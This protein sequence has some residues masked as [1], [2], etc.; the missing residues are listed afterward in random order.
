MLEALFG[1]PTWVSIVALLIGLG[2][3]RLAITSS[4]TPQGA[5]AWV[6]FLLSLPLV[7]IPAWLIFGG[8]SS[9]RG[10]A[11]SPSG[12]YHRTDGG[13]GIDAFTAVADEDVTEG[14]RATLLIDGGPTYAAIHEA[15]DEAREEVLVQFYI[16]RDDEAGRAM[17]DRLVAA[18][19]RGV[20]VCVLCD[21]IGSLQLGRGFVET[22]REAGCEVRGFRG[23]GLA[24]TISVNFRNHRKCV[25]IDGR[26]LFTG[27]INCAQE[28]VDGKHWFDTW[29]DTFVRLDGPVAAQGRASF[30]RDWNDLGEKSLPNMP[31]PEATTGNVRAMLASPGPGGELERGSL[32]LCGLAAQARRR[33]W[34]TTPYLVPH[35][36]LLTALQVAAIRGVDVRILVPRPSDNIVAWYAARAYVDDVMEAGGE[37]REYLPGFMHQK[38]ALVDDDLVSIGTMNLDVRSALLNY[39]MTALI[40]D[41]D[42][43]A[44]VAEMLEADW[45][46]STDR[47][48]RDPSRRIR[49]FAPIARLMAPVL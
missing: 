2:V 13:D 33:L 23:R 30:A 10:S 44:E 22:M 27:G 35:D 38:V 21:L 1:V 36:D 41:R 28:Y 17:R 4:R 37:V 24:F 48:L 32:L 9:I 39:E 11:G 6:V 46:Q 42:F 34:M 31:A 26:T 20:R 15:I 47:H 19:R 43:A 14:N 29:R 3:A 8:V 45:A 25:V 5:T 49:F 12:R 7:A 40:E 16:W 18:A